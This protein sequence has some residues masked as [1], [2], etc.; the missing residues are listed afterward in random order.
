MHVWPNFR[1]ATRI[2][3][4]LLTLAT[5]GALKKPTLKPQE[6]STAYDERK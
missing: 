5:R 2:S 6:L 1:S 4:C 3:P